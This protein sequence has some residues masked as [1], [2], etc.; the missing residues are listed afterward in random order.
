MSHDGDARIREADLLPAIRLKSTTMSTDA[1]VIYDPDR[2][3]SSAWIQSTLSV[4]PQN[5]R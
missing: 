3:D 4:E 2:P 5:V 1:L